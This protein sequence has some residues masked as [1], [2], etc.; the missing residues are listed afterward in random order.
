M[1]SQTD[2]ER[3]KLINPRFVPHFCDQCAAP[4]REYID[5]D[6]WNLFACSQDPRH[7]RWIQSP[8]VAYVVLLDERGD[9]Y[10]VERAI[11]PAIGGWCFPGGYVGYGETAELTIV[12]ETGDEAC[13]R[14]NGKPAIYLGQWFEPG[15]GVTVTGY[16]VRILL[17]D[18]DEFIVNKEATNRKPVPFR[19]MDPGTLAFNGNRLMLAAAR[20]IAPVTSD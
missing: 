19:S 10:V 20:A 5:G 16:L 9:T 8:A 2:R 4:I 15:P 7:M 3:R 11:P 13:V 18:V 17:A 12:H 14:I 1:T 6:D